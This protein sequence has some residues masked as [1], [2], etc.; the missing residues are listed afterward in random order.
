MRRNR[1]IHSCIWYEPDFLPRMYYDCPWFD[2]DMFEGFNRHRRRIDELYNDYFILKLNDEID[3][4]IFLSKLSADLRFEAGD[5]AGIELAR[6]YYNEPQ[7]LLYM[8]KH[9]SRFL[10]HRRGSFAYVNTLLARPEMAPPVLDLREKKRTSIN[11][12]ENETYD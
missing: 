7:L 5:Q 4:M 8:V 9:S 6:M 3:R 11:H 2:D 12:H 10:P 1:N